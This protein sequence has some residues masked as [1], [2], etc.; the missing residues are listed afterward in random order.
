MIEI[1]GP[2]SVVEQIKKVVAKVNITGI[3]G[4][5]ALTTRLE[6]VDGNGR[7]RG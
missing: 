5:A 2:K 6:L 1:S 4:T 7:R 3:T